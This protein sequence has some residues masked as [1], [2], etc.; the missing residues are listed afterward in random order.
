MF[1][2]FSLIKLDEKSPSHAKIL[3]MIS[4]EISGIYLRPR[5]VVLLR[6]LFESR[7]MSLAHVSA[8]HFGGKSPMAKKRVQKLKKAGLLRERPRRVS[9]PSVLFLTLKAFRLLHANGHVSDYP[10]IGE[11]SFEKRSQVSSLTVSHELEVMDV[12]AAIVP[13][14]NRTSQ[15]TVAEFS[16][17]P[18]LYK[19]RA[20]RAN[21][22]RAIVKPDGFVRIHEKEPDGGKY[23]HAFFLEVD[24]STES[25]EVLA[26]KAH[27]YVDFYRTG[28]FAQRF[29]GATEDYKKFPFRV[30][31]VCKTAERRKNLALRLLRNTPAIT[32]QVWL[33]QLDDVTTD[34]LGLIWRRPA[35]YA[36]ETRTMPDQILEPR[37]QS[38]QDLLFHRLLL[39]VPNIDVAFD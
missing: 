39:S 31:V 10:G 6:D 14:I 9:D 5:D 38:Q 24:R 2:P 8:L 34:P 7:I 26:D 12:K 35:D 30:L 22:E 25:L 33:S 18:V 1:P 20:C 13:A 16:T 36:E 17:W 19:F 15:Y 37:V 4:G 29:G 21:G 23:E 11:A 28:G 27:C 32:T 3:I